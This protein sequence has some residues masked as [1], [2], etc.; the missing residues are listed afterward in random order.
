MSKSRMLNKIKIHD[1]RLS[2][3]LM[4]DSYSKLLILAIKC[5]LLTD[6]HIFAGTVKTNGDFDTCTVHQYNKS[7]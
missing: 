6:F 1:H 3:L 5:Y 7:S 4:Q 2:P